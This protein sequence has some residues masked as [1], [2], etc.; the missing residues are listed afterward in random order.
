MF[1]CL[2]DVIHTPGKAAPSADLQDWI[3]ENVG[4]VEGGVV[5]YPCGKVIKTMT[6]MYRHARDSHVEKNICYECPTCKGIFSSR[7]NFQCHIYRKHP[8]LK[9][10]DITKFAYFKR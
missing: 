3:S 8:A 6:N 1:C 5:C 2:V 10:I 9:G 4:K 7:N